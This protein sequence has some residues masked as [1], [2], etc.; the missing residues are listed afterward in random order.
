MRTILPILASLALMHAAG[1]PAQA[2][3]QK[4]DRANSAPEIIVEG[5]KSQR[6]RVRSFVKTLTPARADDQ[7]GR[8][9]E[10][11]CPG[12]VGFAPHEAEQIEA[13]FRVVAKAAGVPL[14]TG[15]CRTNVLMI[16]TTNKRVFIESMPRYAPALVY[17]L[18]PKRVA[19]LARSAGPVSAWQVPAL[20]DQNG[21]AVADAALDSENP[22]SRAPMVVSNDGSRLNKPTQQSFMVSVLVV[23]RHALAQMTTRQFADYAAMRTLAP[24]DPLSYRHKLAGNPDMQL[25]AVSILSL[26]DKGQ[27]PESAPPTVTWW[28]F[29]FLQAL[30]D[31]SMTRAAFMQRGDIQSRMNRIL[32]KVPSDEL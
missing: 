21:L 17:N 19:S 31:M 18:P 27:T 14:A 12:V 16:A 1:A 3:E 8:F 28:D 5:K 2:Q 32:A 6:Q 11:A 15:R 22:A 10:P 30:Y 7:I 23:E 25:P 4:P 29:A 20:L 26:F 9:V 24:I 13:R